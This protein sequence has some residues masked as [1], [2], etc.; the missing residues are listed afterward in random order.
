[1]SEIPA[2]PSN[3]EV[4]AKADDLGEKMDKLAG[5]YTT[6]STRL[7]RL[8]VITYG[9]AIVAVF[10]IAG[11]VVS[12]VVATSAH[13]ASDQATAALSKANLTQQTQVTDRKSVV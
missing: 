6:M 13:H 9:L 5:A 2:Q 12:L 11:L 7:H 8:K 4:L 1:M 3:A 10:S